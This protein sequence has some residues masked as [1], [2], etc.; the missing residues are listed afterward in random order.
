MI[1]AV[2]PQPDCPTFRSVGDEC[3]QKLTP[4]PL[5]PMTWVNEEVDD[6]DLI[7]D[8]RPRRRVNTHNATNDAVDTVANE[9][10][11]LTGLSVLPVER[12]QDIGNRLVLVSYGA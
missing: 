9:I 12:S 4:N 3:A 8:V 6:E 1:I 11:I 2:D 10:E 5:T 7:A